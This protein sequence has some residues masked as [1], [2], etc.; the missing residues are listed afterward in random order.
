MGG[1][2]RLPNG[3]TLLCE[4]AFG[5]LVE[6]NRKNQV[7]WEYVNPHFNEYPEDEARSIF[8]GES[9]ALFRAYKYAPEEISWLRR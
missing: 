9:N 5:R 3:N 8:P 4:A 7:C 2:Q 1:I 6:I